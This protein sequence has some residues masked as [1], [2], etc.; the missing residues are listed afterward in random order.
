MSAGTGG[1]ISGVA[2]FLRES[3]ANDI[4]VVLVDPPG[5][6]LFNKV[7]LNVAYTDEQQERRLHRHRYDTIAE[8]IG[9]DR[10]T[11]NFSVGLNLGVIDD[12]LR[13]TDQ[14]AVDMAHWLLREEGLFVGSSS[15][16]NVSAALQYADLMPPGSC[17][18]TVICDGGQRHLSR[19]WNRQFIIKWGLL[20]PCDDLVAWNERLPY[21]IRE[22]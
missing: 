1:T 22:K 10:I 17:V 20:W 13:I 5:S 8:G 12:A 16:M 19:F 18:V 6:C 11:Q 14:E 4:R 21:R 3:T 7:K 9:L 2:H 15:A